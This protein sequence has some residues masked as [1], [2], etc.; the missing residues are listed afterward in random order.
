MPLDKISEEERDTIGAIVE[1][2]RREH[3]FLVPD[4]LALEL[5]LAACHYYGM[6]LDLAKL[7]AADAWDFVHDLGGIQLFID[8]ATGDLRGYFQPHCR[9]RPTE[10][11]HPEQ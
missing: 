9:R 6:P 2:A 10:P 5:D 7:L 3:P 8:R 11:F 4:A 1:R